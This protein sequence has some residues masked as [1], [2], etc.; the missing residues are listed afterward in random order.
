MGRAKGLVAKMVVYA[1]L[2]D[3]AKMVLF[4]FMGLP[5]IKFLWG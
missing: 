2:V 1:N 5:N 3:W 4:C